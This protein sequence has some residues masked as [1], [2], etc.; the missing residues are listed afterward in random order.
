MDIVNVVCTAQLNCSLDLTKIANAYGNIIYKPNEFQGLRWNHRKIQGSC[1][2]FNNGKLVICGVTSHLAAKLSVRQYARLVQ[3]LAYRVSIS[4]WR[5]QTITAVYKYHSRLNL[6]ELT[7]ANNWNYNPELF[8]AVCYKSGRIHF[9]ITA[10]GRI[11][12]TGG[13]TIEEINDRFLDLLLCI[14]IST[15]DS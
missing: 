6:F 10:R 2:L 1:L 15:P 14:E 12:A 4:Q 8:N 3:R 7:R 11:I 13:R 9:A 5:I